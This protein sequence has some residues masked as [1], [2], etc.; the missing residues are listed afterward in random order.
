[1][2]K[3]IFMCV[4]LNSLF[5]IEIAFIGNLILGVWIKIEI[6]IEKRVC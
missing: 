6:V 3:Y 4:K 2:T 1:M 5:N